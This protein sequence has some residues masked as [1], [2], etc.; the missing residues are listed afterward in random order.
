MFIRLNLANPLQFKGIQQFTLNSKQDL[1]LHTNSDYRLYYVSKGDIAILHS[2]KVTQLKQSEWL[3]LPANV[4]I[5]I[6]DTTDSDETSTMYCLTFNSPNTIEFAYTPF[7]SAKDSY[8]VTL[9]NTGLL[10]DDTDLLLLTTHANEY[11][12]SNV[13]LS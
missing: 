5:A 9:S 6:S 4:Q 2:E 1:N 13:K 12:P 10:E 7:L 11:T 8:G 3:I